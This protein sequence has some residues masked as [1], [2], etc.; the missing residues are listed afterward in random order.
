MQERTDMTTACKLH[1]TF[2]KSISDSSFHQPELTLAVQNYLDL[3]LTVLPLKPLSKI[4]KLKGWTKP[5]FSATISDFTF[6]ANVG[7]VLGRKL[8]DD[9]FLHAVDFDIYDDTL[10]SEFNTFVDS[11]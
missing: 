2:Q 4:P 9:S 3:G 11:L 10:V 1:E 5:D 7:I 6:D 8:H